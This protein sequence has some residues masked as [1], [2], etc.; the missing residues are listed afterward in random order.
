MERTRD[1][2]YI[3]SPISFGIAG[4]QWQVLGD[5]EYGI[6]FGDDQQFLDLVR[7]TADRGV[8]AILAAFREN[9]YKY[10]QPLLFR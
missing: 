8:A 3:V 4:W 1:V 9:V 2:V 5:G 10:I 6:E 7:N